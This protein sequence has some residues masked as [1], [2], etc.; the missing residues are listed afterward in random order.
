M[1][2]GTDA[3]GGADTGAEGRAGGMGCPT[4]GTLGATGGGSG[5]SGVPGGATGAVPGGATG[6]V[7]GGVPRGMGVTGAGVEPGATPLSL[8]GNSGTQI[9]P[10]QCAHFV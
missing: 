2:G 1:D 10:P 8:P 6:G 7:P 9:R 4:P 3:A 5:P